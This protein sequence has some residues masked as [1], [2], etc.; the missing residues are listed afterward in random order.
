MDMVMFEIILITASVSVL[1]LLALVSYFISTRTGDISRRFLA[2]FLFIGAL[3][4]AGFSPDQLRFNT[5]FIYFRA[6]LLLLFIP[7]FYIYIKSV[8]MLSMPPFPQSLKHYVPAT[9]VGSVFLIVLA[10]AWY[11]NY[12]L[13]WQQLPVADIRNPSMLIRWGNFIIISTVVVQ[14][15]IYS[16]T[17]YQTFPTYLSR[18]REYYS[19]ISPFRP[20]WMLWVLAGFVVFYVLADVAMLLSVVGFHY[21]HAVFVVFMVALLFSTAYYGIVVAPLVSRNAQGE[22]VYTVLSQQ[23]LSGQNIPD[24]VSSEPAKEQHR[25]D[26][27]GLAQKLREHIASQ[28]PYLNPILT[29]SDLSMQ[30]ETNTN[31]L[32]RVINETYGTNFNTFIN[33]LRVQKV[34]SL[35]QERKENFSLWGLGQEA[36]FNSKTAF[37]NAFKK[38]T[39]KSPNEYF[40]QMQGKQALTESS[41]E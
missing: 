37:I 4:L 19:D 25:K 36:G 8:F 35:M 16:L 15:F 21:Y 5:V 20:G 34:I 31:Y 32:S 13:S 12:G 2:I 41:S 6:I 7:S 24:A 26:L 23:V 28:Q 3:F 27:S 11:T 1:L 40:N 33:S 18:L 14:L 9:F 22:L 38:E 30:L 10:G 29:L 39:G 17:V